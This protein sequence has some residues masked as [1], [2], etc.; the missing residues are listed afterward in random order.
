MAYRWKAECDGIIKQLTT[1]E[2]AYKKRVKHCWTKGALTTAL[3]ARVIISQIQ[4]LTQY[5]KYAGTYL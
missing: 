1:V 4:Q 5:A 2:V 3:V